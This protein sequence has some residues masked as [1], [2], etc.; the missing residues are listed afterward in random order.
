MLGEMT[1]CTG[2]ENQTHRSEERLKKQIQKETRL[3]WEEEML[4]KP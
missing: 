4:K 1:K 3:L 2:R